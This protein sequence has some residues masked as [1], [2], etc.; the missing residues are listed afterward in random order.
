MLVCAQQRPSLEDFLP[1]YQNWYNKEPSKKVAGTAVDKTYE[2][3]LKKRAAKKTIIVAVMDSGVDID[4]PD[5]KDQIW[6]NA[7]EIP[8]N[9]IDDDKNGYTDDVHGWNFLGNSKGENINIETYEFVR[10]VKQGASH[11]DYAAAK[12]MFDK[13]LKERKEELD[14][15]LESEKK[16]EEARATLLKATG[17]T[18]RRGADLR[19]MKLN[20]TISIEAYNFFVRKFKNGYTEEG[21][22]SRKQRVSDIINYSLDINFDPRSKIIGDDPAVDNMKYGNADVKGPRSNHGTGVAGLIGA[23]R[24]NGFGT[25]GVAKYVKLMPI[26]TTPNGDERDKDI[27]LGIR[28]AV[29]NGADIINMS[30]GKGF[31]PNKAL[32]DEAIRMAEK[33][34]VLIIH[35][36]GNDGVDIDKDIHYPNDTYLDNVKASNFLTVGASTMTPGPELPAVFSNYGKQHVDVFAPGESIITTDTSNLYSVH[37][38]TS[39]SAPI[40]AGIAAMLLAYHPD[41]S[42]AQ[43]IEILKSTVSDYSKEDVLIP[44]VVNEKRATVKFSE[45]C[46]SGGI[47]NAYEAMKLADKL[48]K[49]KSK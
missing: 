13:T 42:P 43:V 16:I 45:L 11:P 10:I 34:G 36:A 21:F 6:T 14:K 9:G 39:E 20:D 18:V 46:V 8:G 31:S 28:Y 3:V 29:E 1:E 5:L 41:L 37:S 23:A 35:A 48:E 27:A 26:R 38:G 4:H 12:A 7:G 15:I 24:D 22:N 30:F 33:K 44:D 19:N 49:K 40:V 47:V 17:V 2:D 32:V 25:N